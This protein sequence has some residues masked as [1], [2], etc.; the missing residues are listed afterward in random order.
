MKLISY[1]R[2]IVAK[3]L[4]V[5]EPVYGEIGRGYLARNIPNIKY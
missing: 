4:Y 2:L 3:P 5:G 1:R